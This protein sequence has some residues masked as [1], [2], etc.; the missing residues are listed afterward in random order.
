[1]KTI[2]ICG[3]MVFFDEIKI[4]EQELKSLGFKVF[5]PSEE[6]TGTDY[7]KLNRKEQSDMK[8]HFID[9]HLEKI[10]NSDAILVANYTKG[11]IKD[12]IWANTFLEMAF[13]Y[14]LKK[15]TYVL[16]S[17]PEQPN[18]VE[19]EGLKPFILNG[20]LKAINNQ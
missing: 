18:T 2:T 20:D 12:Y 3:S 19:I 6:W 13:A 14:A 16:N 4:L 17:I 8:Q 9:R 15:S 5:T 10:R 11:D 7:S 1:M